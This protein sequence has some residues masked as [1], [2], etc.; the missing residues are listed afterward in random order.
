MA[1]VSYCR[2]NPGWV[3][4]GAVPFFQ[5]VLI[6]LENEKMVWVAGPLFLQ[7]LYFAQ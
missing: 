4:L 5:G 1:K 6:K 2:R 7:G 3:S